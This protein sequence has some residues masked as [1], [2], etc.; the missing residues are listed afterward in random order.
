MVEKSDIFAF[1]CFL[2][3]QKEPNSNAIPARLINQHVQAQSIQRKHWESVRIR[4]VK[5]QS[6]CADEHILSVIREIMATLPS[7][8]VAS[9]KVWFTK[10]FSF[11]DF[12]GFLFE[13]SSQPITK[14]KIIQIQI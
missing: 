14:N 5:T 3:P 1:L 13:S 4:R 11:V 12:N 7:Q 8:A 9:A 10:Q 2:T 6:K